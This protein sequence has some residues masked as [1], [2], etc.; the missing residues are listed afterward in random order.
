[1]EWIEPTI[2]PS[3]GQEIVVREKDYSG[4]Y[5]YAI[6]VW[7][8]DIF[9]MPWSN[10]EICGGRSKFST[11]TNIFDGGMTHLIW[12]WAPL[13]KFLHLKRRVEHLEFEKDRL[14]DRC[15]RAEELMYDA[16][17]NNN[18]KEMIDYVNEQIENM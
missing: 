10:C 15:L 9:I 3:E 1:M 13:D 8:N 14:Y 12:S 4:R 7:S 18:D 16:V 2:K 5:R 17:I 11:R 6:G